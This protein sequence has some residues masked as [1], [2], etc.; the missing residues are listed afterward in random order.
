MNIVKAFTNS[1]CHRRKLIF[2]DMFQSL[3]TF[4]LY[5]FSLYVHIVIQILPIIEGQPAN[6]VWKIKIS[7]CFKSDR[8]SYVCYIIC[9]KVHKFNCIISWVIFLQTNHFF[10]LINSHN[11]ICIYSKELGPT[12]LGSG[13][14]IH[15]PLWCLVLCV[16]YL[17]K[18]NLVQFSSEFYEALKLMLWQYARFQHVECHVE[19]RHS[20]NS[21]PEIC[22]T[23]LNSKRIGLLRWVPWKKSTF[24]FLR[25]NN[26]IVVFNSRFSIGQLKFSCNIK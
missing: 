26:L 1:S 17:I 16:K 7:F 19:H 4:P 20:K 11:T 12:S 6:E 2:Q 13:G 22:R 18:S 10:M 24:W 9:S 14:R 3:V 5:S 8:S 15:I 25:T 23:R 21:V